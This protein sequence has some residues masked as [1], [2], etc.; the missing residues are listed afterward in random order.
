MEVS[1]RV[2]SNCCSSDLRPEP[3]SPS[4]SRSFSPV[5]RSNLFICPASSSLSLPISNRNR[6][7]TSRWTFSTSWRRLSWY[8]R[9]IPSTEVMLWRVEPSKSPTC[10]STRLMSTAIPAFSFSRPS[11]SCSW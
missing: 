9:S 8:S 11:L 4:I 6:A 7:W 2:V 10:P 1:V 3:S 5:S